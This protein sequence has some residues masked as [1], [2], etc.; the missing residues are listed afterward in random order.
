MLMGDVI[1]DSQGMCNILNNFFTSTDTPIP[2]QICH[3]DIDSLAVDKE[4]FSKRL[5]QTKDGAPGQNTQRIHVHP[6]RF[7]FTT[8]M[9]D[10]QVP[11]Y[12]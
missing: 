1:S 7:C 11:M 4:M 5:S 10:I 2:D 8:T 6:E 3:V 12:W 9:F